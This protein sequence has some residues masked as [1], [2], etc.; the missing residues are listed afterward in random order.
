ME[1]I[2]QV[3]VAAAKGYSPALRHVSRTERVSTTV[4]HEIFYGCPD[5][6]VKLIKVDTYLQK[7]DVLTKITERINK[8][9]CQGYARAT[10]SH[11]KH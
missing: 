8:C 6:S 4:V 2:A 1:D 3:L 10:I 11:H 5:I 9:G 7:G